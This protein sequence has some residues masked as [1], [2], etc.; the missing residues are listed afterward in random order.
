[1]RLGNARSGVEPDDFYTAAN[2]FDGG[3][4]PAGGNSQLQGPTE[5]ELIL[6]WL[7]RGLPHAMNRGIPDAKNRCSHDLHK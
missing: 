4:Q 5:I 2:P 6:L 3:S 1:M 7:H